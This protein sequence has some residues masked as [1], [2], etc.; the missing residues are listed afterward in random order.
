M[1]RTLPLALLAI[2]LLLT[3]CT[4]KPNSSP[5]AQSSASNSAVALS[6]A[7]KADGQSISSEPSLSAHS[8]ALFEWF[9]SLGV[10]NL[11]NRNY[12]QIYLG[13][14]WTLGDDKEKPQYSNVFLL[15]SNGSEKEAFTL[16][17]RI[18]TYSDENPNMLTGMPY[19]F[20]EVDL[21]KDVIRRLKHLRSRPPEENRLRHIGRQSSEL[22]ELF[23]LARGCFGAGH[24][25]EAEE[26]I[27]YM[28]ETP[29]LKTQEP[30]GKEGLQNALAEDMAKSFMWKAVRDFSDQE[31]P[32]QD[33]LQR[34]REI[35]KHFPQ[36]SQAVRAKESAEILTRMIQEDE[37][38]AQKKA[39]PLEEMTVQ[40][41]VAELIYQLRDQN[42]TQHS[43]P[44]SCDIF[45]D[46]RD[47]GWIP[48]Q[49]EGKGS[50]ATQLV[51]MGDVALEQLIDAVD[52]NSFTRC[53]GFHRNFY[54]SHHVIRVGECCQTIIDRIQPT[55]R[56][57]DIEG[58]PQRAKAAMKI[59]YLGN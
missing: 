42:A 50:P 25:Q 44:G 47:G 16:G 10:P 48:R 37:A 56:R 54:F 29:D 28:S 23:I 35:A 26:L 52:D 12:L 55:G 46:P 22:M 49:V 9:D 32:R 57:F 18:V 58:N 5:Q 31:I 1:R 38:H 11:D 20:K 36:S 15:E 19:E 3:A 30:L 39:R 45:D 21:R 33:L 34:F 8:R 53:V 40:E 14:F 24:Y 2:L 43:Q 17:M 51:K 7:D 59:W 4:D 41:Q 6:E 27:T 13:T